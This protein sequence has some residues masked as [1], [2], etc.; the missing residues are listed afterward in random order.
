MTTPPPSQPPRKPARHRLSRPDMAAQLVSDII[1]QKVAAVQQD[2]ADEQKAVQ[3]KKR[4][5]KLWYF[6]VLLPTLLGLSVWNVVRSGAV[7]VV[8]TPEEIDASIRFRIFLAAQAVEAYR[9]SAGRWPRDLAAVGLEAEGLVYTLVERTYTVADT[10][11]GVPLT[12]RGGESLAP[13]ADAYAQLR[14]RQTGGQ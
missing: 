7:P 9:D 12:Y 1:H 3:R 5:S 8:L 11:H 14:R 4:R 13:F 2:R 6:A 10:S